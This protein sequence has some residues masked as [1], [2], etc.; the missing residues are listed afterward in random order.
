MTPSEIVKEFPKN[1]S[2]GSTGI[3]VISHKVADLPV[4]C[5]A[6]DLQGDVIDSNAMKVNY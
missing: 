3:A 6:K 4:R 2:E 1:G 5:D